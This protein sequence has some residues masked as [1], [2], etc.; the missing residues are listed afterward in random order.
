MVWYEGAG[1]SSP[2]YLY[3]DHQGSVVA[4]ADANGN[5][6]AVNSYDEYGIPRPAPAPSGVAGPFTGTGNTGRFQYTGQAW[7]AE[8]GMY[9]YKARLYSPTLGRFLQTDPIGYD[10]QV[11]LYAYVGN[12][13]VNAVDST[14]QRTEVNTTYATGIPIC[15]GGPG[16]VGCY[17]PRHMNIRITP[18]DQASIRN[19]E[20]FNRVDAD[21]NRYATLSAGPDGV[22][23]FSNLKSTINRSEGETLETF[24]VKTPSVCKS[25]N[26]FI[27]ALFRADASYKDNVPYTLFPD[28]SGDGRNSNSYVTGVLGAAGVDATGVAAKSGLD[29]PGANVPLRLTCQTPNGVCPW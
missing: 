4:V 24:S 16:G 14:G 11:N 27:N 2:R 8:L 28:S 7:L 25:E 5:R 29:I 17:Q 10:D 19:F 22:P 20:V 26:E 6:L 12:D 1:V 21:G 3:S 18:D 13:P 23:E 9:H 15:M